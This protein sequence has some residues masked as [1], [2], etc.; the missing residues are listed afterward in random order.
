M[1]PGPRQV[2]RG[3]MIGDAQDSLDDVIDIREIACV[4]AIIEDVDRLAGEN[5]AGKN[6]KRHVGAPP[7]SV[8]GKKTQARRRDAEE[9]GITM[10]H[11]FVC[12]LARRIE[13]HGMVHVVVFAEGYQCVF[14]LDRTR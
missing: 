4:I 9:M 13:A 14:A 11:Q 12:L 8:N 10:R 5:L 3:T 2:R 1:V 7:W 6:E